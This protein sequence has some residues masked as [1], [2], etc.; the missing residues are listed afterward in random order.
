MVNC[1]YENYGCMGGYLLTSIDYLMVEGSVPNTCIP[2][3]ENQAVCSFACSDGTRN[4]YVKYYCQPGSLELAVNYDDIK[5]DLIN[6][7]PM[8]MGL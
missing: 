2:Y 5:R 7:G 1:N 8:L 4:Q 6:N 3:I